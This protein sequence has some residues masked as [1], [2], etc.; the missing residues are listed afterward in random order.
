VPKK[1]AAGPAPDLEDVFEVR[2]VFSR[3]L[4]IFPHANVHL[5]VTLGGRGNTRRFRRR[6]QVQ[7]RFRRRYKGFPDQATQEE[8]GCGADG[9][10]QGDESEEGIEPPEAACWFVYMKVIISKL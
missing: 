2:I 7:G 9:K 1:L 10:A 4:P 6:E 3:L 5:A 8:E